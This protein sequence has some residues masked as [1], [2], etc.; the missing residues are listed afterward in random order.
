MNM[1]IET[2]LSD[3]NAK[4][5]IIDTEDMLLRLRIAIF[6]KNIAEHNNKHKL[7]FRANA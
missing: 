7:Y 3:L 4:V 5:H 6:E 1:E 2:A